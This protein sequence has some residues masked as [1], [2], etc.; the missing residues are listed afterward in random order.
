MNKLRIPLPTLLQQV[1]FLKDQLEVGLSHGNKDVVKANVDGLAIL[2]GQCIS[3]LS[4]NDNTG[5][6][7]Q[8]IGTILD[9]QRLITSETKPNEI[10]KVNL[11]EV[12]KW[13][14]PN[15]DI[16]EPL[17]IAKSKIPNA[18]QGLFTRT[19]I[20]RGDTI[21][22]SRVQVDD[23]GDF[24]KDWEK[25]PIAAMTNHHP[26]PNMTIIREYPPKGSNKRYKK[27]CYF[28]ASR[29]IQPHE[30]LVSDYRDKGWA[31]Y[32]YYDHIPL[33]YEEWDR[34]CLRTLSPQGDL[35]DIVKN[36]P[37]DFTSSL[38]T[39]G[40]PALFYASTRV[41][42]VPSLALALGGLFLTG[43]SGWDKLK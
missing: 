8:A 41:S 14:S 2:I 22:P 7:G 30:E 33:P 15:G 19:K 27:V 9:A 43:Y 1:S 10:Y 23:S 32:D 5:I 35:I 6:L 20:Y 13:I 37:Q 26:I 36:N 38:G 34:Q 11:L 40:G 16:K 12:Q 17:Y 31:E 39:I 18:G 3:D 21:G 29:D 4:T 25:F 42:G 28:V 24:F